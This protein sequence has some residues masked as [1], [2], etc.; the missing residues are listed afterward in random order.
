MQLYKKLSGT[1]KHSLPHPQE[2]D[3]HLEWPGSEITDQTL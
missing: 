2:R 1:F 3:T